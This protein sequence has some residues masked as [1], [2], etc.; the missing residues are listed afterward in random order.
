MTIAVRPRPALRFRGRSFLALVLAP[1]VP[2]RDWLEDLDAVSERSPGF[3][4]G[5]PI[6]ADVSNLKPSKSE[7]KFLLAAFKMRNIRIVGLEGAAPENVEPD[8]PPQITGGK[9]AGEIDIHEGSENAAAAATPAAHSPADDKTLMIEG[10]VRSGQSILHPEGDVTV[11]GSVASGAE[12][13]AGG[14][15]HVYGALRGR[16]IAGC[17]GNSRARIFCRKFEAELIA[18]DGLYKTA[19]DL[20]SKFHG[21]PIQ[22]NLDGDSIILQ[23]L[24]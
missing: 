17:T 21:Q 15:I 2:L 22:V 11:L 20:G 13:V 1:E 23:T 9:P 24:D 10:S 14:S 6:I 4:S 12:I 16:A 8:M 18:I 5:R 3:F 7:L 19:D